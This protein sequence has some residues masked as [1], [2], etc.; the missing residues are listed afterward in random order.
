MANSWRPLQS[1]AWVTALNFSSNGYWYNYFNQDSCIWPCDADWQSIQ[2]AHC[3]G[4]NTGSHVFAQDSCGCNPAHGPAG[5]LNA[6]LCNSTDLSCYN[7]WDSAGSY[8]HNC[9][10]MSAFTV[11]ARL[12]CPLRS[13][14]L[15]RALPGRTR[16]G[17]LLRKATTP[18]KPTTAC[19][20]QFRPLAALR[21]LRRLALRTPVSLTSTRSE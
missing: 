18:S 10:G 5:C 11:S 21:R 14:L 15:R 4:L 12:A 1:P 17:G 16:S 2:V 6:Q 7:A 8:Y 3:S 20:R 19:G 9:A 13:K